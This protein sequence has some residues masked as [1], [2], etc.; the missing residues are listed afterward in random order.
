MSELL[1]D[2]GRYWTRRADSFA[3][4]MF[5][6]ENEQRWLK[7]LL[8]ELPAG[9]TL[10]VLDIGTGP[11][12]F[13]ILLARQGYSVT[14]VDYTPAMLEKAMANAGNLKDQIVFR[15]M[16][17]QQLDFSDNSFDA[18]VTRNLT[19]NLERPDA[20]YE[21]WRRVLKPGGILLNFDAG[22]YE[23]LFDEEKAAGFQ[24]D[25]EN[26]RKAG[27]HDCNSYSE[28]GTMEEICKHLV[29]SRSQRPQADLQMLLDAGF[30]RVSVDT[31]I[32]KETW[33]HAERINYA[34]TP[35]F[36]LRAQK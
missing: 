3:E 28:S 6:E 20:A 26:V 10:R 4:G 11:G 2:I 25:R 7:V 23:Y 14:A 15:Q 27:I 34:S 8:R 19:W 33:N 30:S 29:L 12:F 32:W 9:K 22:W 17:A 13:A 36:L 18:I 1:Q 31:A 21:E 24:R 35:G 16:D 5:T